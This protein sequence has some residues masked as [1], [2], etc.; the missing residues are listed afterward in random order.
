MPAW[1]LEFRG[2]TSSTIATAPRDDS[3]CCSVRR[4]SS[5]EQLKYHNNGH[6]NAITTGI[7]IGASSCQRRRTEWHDRDSS[8]ASY[9]ECEDQEQEEEG[10]EANGE[11]S[12]RSSWRGR[13]DNRTAKSDDLEPPYVT[14][15]VSAECSHDDYDETEF[16]PGIAEFLRTSR[17]TARSEASG[18]ITR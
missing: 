1:L 5:A 14:I 4:R 9:H 7:C 15:H 3:R 12:T 10:E 8:E 2:T 18:R 16:D 11:R 17:M 13:T 6:S